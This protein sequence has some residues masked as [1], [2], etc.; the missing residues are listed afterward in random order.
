[1][2]DAIVAVMKQFDRPKKKGLTALQVFPVE[3]VG[4]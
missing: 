1:M 2:K 3:F 4:F